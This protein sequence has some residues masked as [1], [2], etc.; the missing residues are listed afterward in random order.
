MVAP[1]LVASPQLML[2]V[3][4]SLVPGSLNTAAAGTGEPMA[5]EAAGSV[6]VLIAGA[7]FPTVIVAVR[8]TVA[9]IASS[10]RSVA[11]TVP[12]SVQVI[13]GSSVVVPV[14]LHVV[15]GAA[16]TENVHETPSGSSSG[17]DA[18][19]DSVIGLPSV[20]LYGPPALTVGGALT[21][22]IRVAK[23]LP[24]SLSLTVTL[25]VYVPALAYVWPPATVPAPVPIVSVTV[26]G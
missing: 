6:N 13:D 21:T 12:L 5:T 26:P 7:A 25:T 8:T 17:S 23:L 9:L 20:P 14:A 19:P 3:W 24:P 10:T 18:D 15:P 4:V 16:E 22:T 2:A 11:V 1:E